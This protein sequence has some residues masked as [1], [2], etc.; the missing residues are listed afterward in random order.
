MAQPIKYDDLKEVVEVDI[1]FSNL[2]FGVRHDYVGL[3]DERVFVPITVEI[4]NKQLSFRE[5]NGANL[6]KLAVY[7]IVTS[8]TNRVVQE[9]DE[10][11]ILEYGTAQMPSVL[12]SRSSYQRIL[13]LERGIRYR[14]DL[15]VKDLNSNE[16]GVT[17]LGLAP[18][19][20]KDQL[21]SSSLILSDVI[22]PLE[23][24]PGAQEMFVLG[25]IKVRPSVRNVFSLQ[26]PLGM[27]LQLFGLGMDQG[28]QSPSIETRYR[29]SRNGQ[30]VVQLVGG[31]QEGLRIYSDERVA[32]VKVLPT[33][34]LEP[35]K[36]RVE[37]EIR[38]LVNQ[39]SVR[40]AQEFQLVE[41]LT[42]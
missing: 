14:L 24:A 1:T 7:G 11:L 17:R 16:V 4:E 21:E 34:G 30:T 36:Y 29:I 20:F 25:D 19:S 31:E 42:S 9:F 28:T 5:Q 32:L 23:N 8:I 15:V 18:P 6:A 38:D 39:Q 26:N 33:N 3:D 2:E 10:D 40:A 13:L 22:I 35:G 37:V 12:R 27:Y 41:S